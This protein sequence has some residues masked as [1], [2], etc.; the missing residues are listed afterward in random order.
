MNSI[1]PL[2]GHHGDAMEVA[3]S[4]AEQVIAERSGRGTRRNETEERYVRL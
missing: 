1:G 3:A 4:G 2:L